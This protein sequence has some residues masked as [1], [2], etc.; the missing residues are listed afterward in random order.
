MDFGR[1]FR[2][3][4]TRKHMQKKRRPDIIFFCLFSAERQIFR[5]CCYFMIIVF[6]RFSCVTD[7]CCLRADFIAC[8]ISRKSSDSVN[9][10][11]ILDAEPG[12]FSNTCH[13]MVF[14][15][16]ILKLFHVGDVIVKYWP[17]LLT[18]KRS[19]KVFRRYSILKNDYF[20][21]PPSDT[22]RVTRRGHTFLSGS[23]K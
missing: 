10:H 12:L 19:K 15:R 22:F 7:V 17:L 4:N 23:C 3:V 18:F 11:E 1:Y 14:F 21:C 9:F 6:R 13:L 5:S 8:T 16:E 2:W 20:R